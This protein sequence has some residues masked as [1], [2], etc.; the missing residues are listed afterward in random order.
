MLHE[1]V[2]SALSSLGCDS[3]MLD[4]FDSHS[5]IALEFS[6]IPDV[7]ISKQDELVLFWTRLCEHNV[8]NIARCAENILELLLQPYVCSITGQLQMC[9]DDGYT[10]LKCIIDPK[11]LHV[12]EFSNALE[13]FYLA[14]E[15]YTEV[16]S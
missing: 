9:E 14:I 13:E 1:L 15:K 6:T 12:D 8:S 4:G 11:M 5:T 7:Y 2:R 10:V 16:L 3:N